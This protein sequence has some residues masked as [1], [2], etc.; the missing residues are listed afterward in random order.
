VIYI[1][2]YCDGVYKTIDGAEN[3]SKCSTVSF[4]EWPDSLN[5]SPTQPCW[6]FGEYY[7]INDIEIDPYNPEH[8]W[9]GFGGRGLFESSD[10][11][12]SWNRT[13]LSLP[14]ILDV[15]YI[16]VN[17][18]NP[19]KIFVGSG[20]HNYNENQPLDN[21]GLYYTDDGGK[22]WALMDSVPNGY[23]YNISCFSTEP[24]N[25]DH[26]YVGIGSAGEYDFSWGLIESTDGGSK[27]NILN[28]DYIYHDIFIN[29]SDNQNLFSIVYTG[30]MDFFLA[31]SEDGGAT[32]TP[33]ITE[34]WV[35]GLYA[36]KDFNLYA[37]E[38]GNVKKSADNG[39]TWSNIDTLCA[40]R[41]V[42]LLNRCE[43]NY[44]NVENI[45]FGTY[46][47]T[48]KS[49]DGGLNCDLKNANLTNSYILDIEIHPFNNNVIYAG[50]GQGLWKSTDGCETW[51]QVNDERI[52]V[53]RYD[54]TNPDTLYYG[55]QNLMRS[56]D[57][58]ETFT[59]IRNGVLG[60]IRDIKIDQH[61]SN[62]IYAVSLYYDFYLYKSTNYGNEWEAINSC[63][64][65]HYPLVFIDPNSSDTLY[66]S[67][68][69]SLD[70]GLTWNDVTSYSNEVVSVHPYDSNIIFFSDR[71]E[72]TVTYD[73]GKTFQVL[74]TYTNWLA[75]VPAIGNL[76]FDNNY[77]DN[78]FYCTPNN[79]IHY[80][81][82]SGE[83]WSVLEGSYEKRTLDVIPL[84]EEGK[85]YIA[86]HGNGVWI[87][88]NV[89]LGIDKGQL[90]IDNYELYQNYPNP[91]NPVTQIKFA[92]AK[93]AEVKLSV[94]NITGQ[95][96]SQLASGTINAGVHSVDFNGAKLN[97]G[98]YYYTLEVDGKAMT[99]RMVLM[100]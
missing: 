48:Y 21:G 72:L 63:L 27:W 53:I 12:S 42:R 68:E 67:N 88:E 62:V 52:K 57:G 58:G 36:D 11:G 41:G 70:G 3:W 65:K 51:N 80:T 87:G 61:S 34:N 9:I 98:V 28:E 90:L 30:Y 32:W 86:T 94:Y 31:E 38:D 39:I 99:R 91:F 40:G 73:W 66:F 45:Y 1:G 93:T 82:D 64:Q 35:T 56:Y 22:N 50:G 16:H 14:D 85:I 81:N 7:P 96:V 75:P 71:N 49:T 79:G 47:G 46:C 25:E 8:L 4:P 95:L 43:T 59:D 15:D 55:G 84:V 29:P 10:G 74:E 6:W 54:Q 92:L 5:N 37:E 17:S 77:P 24:G 78:M 44:S 23:T 2:T 20:N 89:S 100:K 76:V 13:D 19:D 97:S 69:R 33:D 60:E 83:N 18:T 26:I